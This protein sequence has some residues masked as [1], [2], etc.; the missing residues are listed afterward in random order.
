MK[1]WQHVVVPSSPLLLHHHCSHPHYHSAA[2]QGSP[3]WI[4]LG[5]DWPLMVV[6]A[7]LADCGC[8]VRMLLAYP[9]LG[10]R[11]EAMP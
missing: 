10:G 7:V 8:S 4:L 1:R 3:H 11:N 2:P 9:H 5:W 6:Q